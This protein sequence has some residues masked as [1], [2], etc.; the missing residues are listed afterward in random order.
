MIPIGEG[1]QIFPVRCDLCE[2]SLFYGV[3]LI[4]IEPRVYTMHVSRQDAQTAADMARQH[5]NAIVKFKVAIDCDEARE[6]WLE[7]DGRTVYSPG[8]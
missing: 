3:E 2:A 4:T 6:W 5:S 1:A 8:P 7:F